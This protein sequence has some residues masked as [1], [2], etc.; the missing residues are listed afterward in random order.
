MS[1]SLVP[2]SLRS[3]PLTRSRG[4]P[5]L[6][7]VTLSMSARQVQPSHLPPEFRL[8]ILIQWQQAYDAKYWPLEHA[9]REDLL[10]MGLDVQ[11]M[12]C[13]AM[14]QLNLLAHLGGFSGV[15]YS[16]D[17]GLE[18]VWAHS[19]NWR[20]LQ[21][22]SSRPQ[23][24]S[25]VQTRLKQASPDPRPARGLWHGQSPFCLWNRKTDDG[26]LDAQDSWCEAAPPSASSYP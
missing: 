10:R 21:S 22:Q 24:D 12:P 15:V 3:S 1:A 16:A 25:A 6:R 17:D 5:R 8:G 7:F 11:K 23:V 19:R 2:A 14:R 4:A 9:L 13:I 26:P 18:G 20:W